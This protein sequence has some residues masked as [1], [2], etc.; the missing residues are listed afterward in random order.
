MVGGMARR[1]KA[2][3]LG[4]CPRTPWSYFALLAPLVSGPLLHLDAH[5]GRGQPLQRVCY[6]LPRVRVE[7]RHDT[8]QFT[9]SRLGVERQVHV[10]TGG[11]LAHG[12]SFR[13]LPV[14]G[15]LARS[16]PRRVVLVVLGRHGVVNCAYHRRL[17][18]TFPLLLR[19]LPAGRSTQRS[20][21]P[22]AHWPRVRGLLL[23]RAPTKVRHVRVPRLLR[24]LG[25]LHVR[26]SLVLH[27]LW[28][29]PHRMR[30]RAGV[31]VL[32]VRRRHGKELGRSGRRHEGLVR[33]REVRL[34]LGPPGGRAAQVRVDVECLPN[35]RRQVGPL[36]REVDI[37][38]VRLVVPTRLQA[39]QIA[40]YIRRL[41]IALHVGVR[42]HLAQPACPSASPAA[43]SA[44][45]STPRKERRRTKD[46]D[47]GEAG[48]V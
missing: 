26:V 25:R 46:A 7:H 18:Y 21:G 37:H 13:H 6:R 8:L 34:P 28:L 40:V 14:S 41:S 42:L 27:H 4:C 16:A 9:Q 23:R 48:D 47:E 33:P 45:Y 11:M 5:G 30:V 3:L 36:L 12:R 1:R 43:S 35:L 19:A 2:L 38:I 17:P 29:S 22:V 44:S 31:H 15:V 32:L 39:Q 20:H 24:E 10:R